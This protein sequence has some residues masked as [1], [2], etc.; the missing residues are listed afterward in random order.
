VNGSEVAS[1]VADGTAANKYR[2]SSGSNNSLRQRSRRA[3]RRRARLGGFR[4]DCSTFMIQLQKKTARANGVA[5]F[6]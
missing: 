6:R 5:V 3:A 4:A 2:C 1:S